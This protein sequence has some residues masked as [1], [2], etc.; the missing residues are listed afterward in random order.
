MSNLIKGFS[1]TYAQWGERVAF[2]EGY[3]AQKLGEAK[4]AGRDAFSLGVDRK[5]ARDAYF[6]SKDERFSEAAEFI[7]SDFVDIEPIGEV[8]DGE[9][10]LGMESIVAN[11]SEYMD[12]ESLFNYPDLGPYETSLHVSQEDYFTAHSMNNAM[13][14]GSFEH[15][16]AG[17]FFDVHD[18]GTS[19]D[20]AF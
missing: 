11:E 9:E 7:Q 13:D 14:D 10:T 3:Q 17:G 18:D 1:D 12:D 2:N 8:L 15:W 5:V 16:D 4:Q 6:D 20:D 19:T